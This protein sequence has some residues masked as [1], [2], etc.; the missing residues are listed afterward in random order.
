MTDLELLRNR[1]VWEPRDQVEERLGEDAALV[2]EAL[3][4]EAKWRVFL[5]EGLET[6]F[7]RPHPSESSCVI[8]H[9]QTRMLPSALDDLLSKANPQEMM[10]SH[11][12]LRLGVTPPIV[13]L[14]RELRS[15]WDAFCGRCRV[16]QAEEIE[17]YLAKNGALLKS[18]LKAETAWR[19]AVEEALTGIEVNILFIGDDGL[20]TFE[21]RAMTNLSEAEL[22]QA[23]ARLGPDWIHQGEPHISMNA[24]HRVGE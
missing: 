11:P 2:K 1:C 10:P 16:S 15:S 19:N 9:C 17:A 14:P 5:G 21:V 20:P 13:E 23:L 6:I 4:L 12:R 8:L 22:S 7:L 24:V 3:V 18:L